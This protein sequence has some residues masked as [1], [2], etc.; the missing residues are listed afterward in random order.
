MVSGL[1]LQAFFTEDMSQTGEA[2]SSM[3]KTQ[4]MA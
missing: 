4:H 1:Y 2:V 3:Q